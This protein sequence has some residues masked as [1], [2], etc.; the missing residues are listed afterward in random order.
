MI[1]ILTLILVTITLKRIFERIK[2]IKFYKYTL[3]VE[4]EKCY[5]KCE[6]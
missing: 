3:S 5:P 1:Y 4:L 2:K 6:I